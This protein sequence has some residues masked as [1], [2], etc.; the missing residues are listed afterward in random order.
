MVK[1]KHNRVNSF[2]GHILLKVVKY[3]VDV[4]ENK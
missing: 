1:N 2:L 3:L 4:E